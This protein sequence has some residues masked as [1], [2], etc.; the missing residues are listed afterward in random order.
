MQA[1]FLIA[2]DSRP[3]PCTYAVPVFRQ[4]LQRGSPPPP[5]MV[6]S[7]TS[8]LTVLRPSCPHM[9]LR[10]D[11]GSTSVVAGTC[12]GPRQ[13]LS[14][15]RYYLHPRRDTSRHAA[16]P[17]SRAH[18]AQTGARRKRAQTRGRR[19][20]DRHS[21]D[22][23]NT[24]TSTTG[25]HFAKRPFQ[26]GP[27]FPC[28]VLLSARQSS[29]LAQRGYR[30]AR[31]RH[32]GIDMRPNGCTITF[33][34]LENI[35]RRTRVMPVG[36][37]SIHRDLTRP[38]SSNTLVRVESVGRRTA[39]GICALY[40]CALYQSISHNNPPFGYHDQLSRTL[41]LTHSAFPDRLE[42]LP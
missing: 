21:A 9:A 12:S 39:C 15:H 19:A 35:G 41:R 28:R 2:S 5:P 42:T 22:T 13:Y 30:S 17:N 7:S 1:A 6:Q 38:I 18:R 25:V 27:S 40:H 26:P 16:I 10:Q 3:C 31:R 24:N 34:T 33:L 29:T 32:T 20:Q 11:G 4:S 8:E 23:D 36:P 14:R 37:I